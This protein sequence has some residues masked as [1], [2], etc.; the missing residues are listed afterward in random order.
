M[1]RQSRKVVGIEYVPEAIED[2]KENARINGLDNTLFYAGDMKDILTEDF[3]E[4]HVVQK[5]SLPIRLVPA[6]M[7]M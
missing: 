3:I 1:A 7:T 2:A 5:S 4:E 6:C